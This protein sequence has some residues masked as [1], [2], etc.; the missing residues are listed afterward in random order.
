MDLL[1]YNES[2]I[3]EGRHWNDQTKHGVLVLVHRVCVE[4][5]KNVVEDGDLPFLVAIPCRCF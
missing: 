2:Y 3:L 4:A 5:C 1:C